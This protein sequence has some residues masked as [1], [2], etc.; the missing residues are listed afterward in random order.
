M[1]QGLFFAAGCICAVIGCA[2]IFLPVLPAIPFFLL[3]LLCFCQCSDRV[4]HRIFGTKLGKKILKILTEDKPTKS[5]KQ[6]ESKKD[7]V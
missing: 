6:S 1:K 5:R 3:A 4:K 2:G 7:P